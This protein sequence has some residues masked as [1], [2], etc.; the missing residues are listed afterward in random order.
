M[1]KEFLQL[2]TLS[3]LLTHFLPSKI[4]LIPVSIKVRSCII[5]LRV[6]TYSV[7][8]FVRHCCFGFLPPLA[9][10]KSR[11]YLSKLLIGQRGAKIFQLVWI[12]RQTRETLNSRRLI[13]TNRT[14]GCLLRLCIDLTCKSF[15]LTASF[16]SSVTLTF[17]V[18]S[19]VTLSL[20]SGMPNR[21]IAKAMLEGRA[22]GQGFS[23]R[24]ARYKTTI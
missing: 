3:D 15:A 23:T 1:S 2:T 17:S 18:R 6:S 5:Q 11:H 13:R 16:A 10:S 8:D 20:R 19:S 4:L 22:L 9:M 21:S 7:D 24:G 12:M 14:A